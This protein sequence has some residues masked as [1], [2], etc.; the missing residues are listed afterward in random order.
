MQTFTSCVARS[1]RSINGVNI[2][3]LYCI[4][5][6]TGFGPPERLLSTLAG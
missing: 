2:V 4:K 6:D 3:F 1:N 5:I